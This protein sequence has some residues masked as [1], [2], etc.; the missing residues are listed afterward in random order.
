LPPTIANTIYQEHEIFDFLDNSTEPTN[1][2]NIS[3]VQSNLYNPLHVPSIPVSDR[4]SS[5]KPAIKLV[6]TGGVR[7]HEE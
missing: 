6:T 4:V 2:I 1:D 3:T 5:T 7:L